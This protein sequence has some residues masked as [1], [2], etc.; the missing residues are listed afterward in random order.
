MV[1]HDLML[2]VVV[3]TLTTFQAGSFP[4]TFGAL[5]KLTSLHLENTALGTLPDT[6]K[7][8]TSLTLIHNRRIGS[9][10]P[11]SIGGSALRSLYAHR[12]EPSPFR[13]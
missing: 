8:L 3:L 10:L 4:T 13:G 7:T 12:A 9:S 6:V 1:S 11:P 5:T 2:G